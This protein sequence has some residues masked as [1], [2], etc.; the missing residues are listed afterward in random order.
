MTPSVAE[1][2]RVMRCKACEEQKETAMKIIR[3]GLTLPFA[4]MADEQNRDCL[5]DMDPN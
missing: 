2:V 5:G 3:T 1:L 4:L